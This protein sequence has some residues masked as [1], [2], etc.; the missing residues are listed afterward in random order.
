MQ[1]DGG[2]NAVVRGPMRVV[3]SGIVMVSFGSVMVCMASIMNCRF[4]GLKLIWKVERSQIEVGCATG[5]LYERLE[6]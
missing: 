5:C 4:R 6:S 2:T 1:S 3:E